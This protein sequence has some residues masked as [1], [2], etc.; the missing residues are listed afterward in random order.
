MADESTT[1]DLAAAFEA[2]RLAND[3][4]RM[5]EL[6]PKVYPEPA[7]DRMTREG[8]VWRDE[9]RVK[10]AEKY[11]TDF[12][13]EDVAKGTGSLSPRAIIAAVNAELEQNRGHQTA[14]LPRVTGPA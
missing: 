2:A 5:A 1:E 4:P 6:G 12:A 8:S 10:L 7:E 11:R 3:H 13:R 9:F 14:R